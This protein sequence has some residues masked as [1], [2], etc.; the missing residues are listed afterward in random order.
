MQ[1]LI[2]RDEDVDYLEKIRSVENFK[3]WFASRKICDNE[4]LAKPC[5]NFCHVDKSWYIVTVLKCSTWLHVSLA[6]ILD[7]HI[8]TLTNCIPFKT[9][10]QC[11]LVDDRIVWFCSKSSFLGYFFFFCFFFLFLLNK[12]SVCE[13]VSVCL[14]I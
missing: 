4:A 10:K 9:F 2:F 13:N 5:K 12:F 6:H 1:R 3:V 14:G 8:I 11:S 7:N